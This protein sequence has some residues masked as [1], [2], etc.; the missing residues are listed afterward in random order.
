MNNDSTVK[1]KNICKIQGHRAL[2]GQPGLGNFHRLP[3]P[4]VGTA[5]ND[6]IKNT[7]RHTFNAPYT[8]W[9]HR[10]NFAFML[11][12]EIVDGTEKVQYASFNVIV[13]PRIAIT[14]MQVEIAAVSEDVD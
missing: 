1:D 9:R 3:L 4:V 14:K 6:E 10:V 13:E 5:S 7:W 12:F 11:T 2:S 8:S